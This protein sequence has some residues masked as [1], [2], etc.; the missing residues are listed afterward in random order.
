M[1]D[2]TAND[3]MPMQ[4]EGDHIGARKFDEEQAAFARS[5]K[6]AEKAAEAEAAL[7]GPE[8]EEL[9]AAR[10]AAAKGKSVKTPG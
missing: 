10:A 7:D 1:P 9:E 3:P 8:G 4:G 6:V 5:G 2:K